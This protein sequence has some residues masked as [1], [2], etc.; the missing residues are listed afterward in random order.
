MPRAGAQPG[1]QTPPGAIRTALPALLV[2]VCLVGGAL[3]LPAGP[4]AGGPTVAAGPAGGPAGG[5][6]TTSELGPE[7]GHTGGFGEPTCRSC[8]FDGPEQPDDVVLSIEGTPAAWSPGQAYEL[9]VVLHG[10]PLRRGGFQLAVRYSEGD[11]AGTQA[12][13]LAG[14]DRRV[15]LTESAGI[16]YLHHTLEGTRP[17][18]PGQ[19]RWPFTWTAP[20]RGGPIAFHVAA[21]AAN[22]DNSEFGDLIISTATTLPPKP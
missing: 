19:I 18:S 15:A 17:S 8:H 3:L 9:E 10:E 20:E 22:D 6:L 14:N 1:E 11:R 12:G 16:A 4:A 7:P 13:S 21:N 2:A 5:G